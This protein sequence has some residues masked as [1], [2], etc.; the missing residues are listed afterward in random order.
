MK[1][2]RYYL[3]NLMII[4]CWLALGACSL[5][6]QS[7]AEPE[8]PREASEWEASA[9]PKVRILG[10]KADQLVPAGTQ[11]EIQI[12]NYPVDQ[13]WQGFE[14][15]IND[16]EPQR[17]HSA[18]LK[19]VLPEDQLR[20][21]ANFLKVYLVRSWGESIK[22]PEAFDFVPFFY[23]SKT[24]LSWVAPKRPMLSL[25]SPR[26]EYSGEAAKKILFDFKVQNPERTERV[27][28][29]HYTLNGKKLELSTGKAYHFY[30]LPEGD[31]ELRVEVV[32]SRGIPL[33]QEV[34]RSRSSFRVLATPE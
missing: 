28:K 12:E 2:K 8:I 26:G 4:V 16:N 13:N 32:N 34:T 14:I 6:T 11:I 5:R 25:V 1:V 17:F 21:G 22:H 10:L 19:W 30:N 29:V 33:G 27:Y 7:R 31:Y 24:G 20:R 23:E 3:K 15:V 18:P 9:P